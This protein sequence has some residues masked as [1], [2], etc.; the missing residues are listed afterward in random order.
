MAG[1]PSPVTSSVLAWAVEED[2]RDLL[3]LAEALDTDPDTLTSWVVGEERPLQG[4]VTKLAEVL[5]RPRAL[6][7]MPR[8]PVAATLP[9]SFRHPPGE[10]RQVSAQAR[11]KVRQARRVQQA[12]S[13]AVRD[14]PAVEVPLATVSTDAEQTGALARTWLG[15]TDAEQQGWKSDYAALS[16]WRQALEQRDVL[17]FA[18]DV[19]RD[20]VRGFSAW[21][22]HAPLV[23]I[24][25][26][27][28]TPA[29][30]S[31]TL[32]HELGHLL[33]RQD[34]ACI[35]SSP[36]GESANGIE[37]WCERFAAAVLM[38]E[39]AVRAWAERRGVDEASAGLD[40]V[41]AMMTQFRVSA[42][43]SALRLIALGYAQRELYP[44]VRR[45][46][47]PKPATAEK[48]GS[49]FSPSRPVLRQ[50]QYGERVLRT[51]INDLPPRDALSILHLEVAD[52]RRLAETVPGV[53]E[54]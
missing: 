51:V 42:L 33:L 39:A 2:G 49:F 48:N 5:K 23:V 4:Q 24:N 31:F 32:M 13:W 1:K 43:A 40:D 54:I 15:V 21:D 35:E 20:D 50:R 14:D 6:F 25:T 11:R 29:A 28:V 17:V 12:V 37:R 3:S 36:G 53:R 26:T 10:E 30:R 47:T 44:Q 52:V 41:K 9:P 19:G 45:V 34:A 27:G 7:F 18:L 16:G 8:P 38:S 46:F 22:E